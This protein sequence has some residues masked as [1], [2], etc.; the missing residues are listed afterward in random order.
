MKTNLNPNEWIVMNALWEHSPRTLSET[1]EAIG[2][3]ADWNYKTYQSYMVLLEKKGYVT[4]EKRGRDKFYAPAV[5]REACV[6][7]ESR[8]LLKKLESDS[9]KLLVASMVR[10]GDLSAADRMELLG[11]LEALIEKEDGAK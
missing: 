1:I 6:E 2:D 9:V 11:L 10:E 7:E 5:T 4:S 3:K 8:S